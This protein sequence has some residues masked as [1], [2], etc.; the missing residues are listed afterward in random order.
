[1]KRALLP[2]FFILTLLVGSICLLIDRGKVQAQELPPQNAQAEVVPLNSDVIVQR[3]SV[4]S[5]L[6]DLRAS[7]RGQ[8]LEYRDAEASFIIARGELE[9]LQTL[10]ATE[11]AV[12]ATKK[13]QNLRAL[14]LITY[15]KLLKLSILDTTTMSL[16][17][18]TKTLAALE[19]VQK[20]LESHQA[21]VQRAA[22]RSDLQLVADDFSLISPRLVAEANFGPPRLRKAFIATQALVAELESRDATAAATLKQAERKRA[23]EQT[24]QTLKATEEQLLQVENYLAVASSTDRLN[25]DLEELFVGIYA[26]KSQVLSYIEEVYGSFFQGT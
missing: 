17:V 23:F 15:T 11:N 13:V 7:L 2:S 1:M 8:I 16:P 24:T 9:K 3:E 25:R 20:D 6:E 19:V 18:K 21:F 22:T 14:V 5:Q 10:A 26:G 12:A 4:A